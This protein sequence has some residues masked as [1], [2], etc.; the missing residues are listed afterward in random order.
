VTGLE[1][2]T[3]SSVSAQNAENHTSKSHI[4]PHEKDNPSP[5]LQE[6]INSWPKLSPELR[7]AVLAIIKSAKGDT[8]G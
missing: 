3:S 5:D 6:I 2:A 1:P 7:A 4:S 8:S